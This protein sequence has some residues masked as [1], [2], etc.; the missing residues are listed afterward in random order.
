MCSL[1]C[2]FVLKY[3]LIYSQISIYNCITEDN[4]PHVCSLLSTFTYMCAH[5]YVHIHTYLHVHLS[6]QKQ[7]YVRICAWSYTFLFDVPCFIFCKLAYTFTHASLYICTN[8]Q[9]H[10]TH[11]C[12]NT[13]RTHRCCSIGTYMC[14]DKLDGSLWVLVPDLSLMACQR[15][16]LVQDPSP[17]SLFPIP[18]PISTF[19]FCVDSMKL[20][21]KVRWRAGSFS[22]PLVGNG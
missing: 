18:V 3:V 1:R 14:P 4:I 19:V 12:V 5:R 9:S 6:P 11:M 8:A 10:N 2:W 22:P 15:G 16:C 13:T 21:G 7:T 20:P 17:S